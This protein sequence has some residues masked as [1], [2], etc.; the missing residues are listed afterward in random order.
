MFAKAT[1]SKLRWSTTRGL[2]SVED[3]WDLNLT[4]LNNIAKGLKKELK[5][6][7]EEDFLDE[8]SEE[9][10]ITKLKFDV[11]LEIL[12][13]KK[14]ENKSAAEASE[15]KAHNQMIMGLI[16]EKEQQDLKSKSVDELKA[17]LK[18]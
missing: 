9:D 11:V 6:E 18:K 13:I 8:K 7:A 2:L 15:I 12:N 3:L 17:L 5:A 1:R 14:A 16:V 10:T 4:S